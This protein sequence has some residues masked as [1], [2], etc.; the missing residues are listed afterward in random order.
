[1]ARIGKV[2]LAKSGWRPCPICHTTVEFGQP[3]D[4][5]GAEAKR[6]IESAF[7]GNT[8]DRV[9]VRYDEHGFG[10]TPAGKLPAFDAPMELA[11]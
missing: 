1:M 11:R 5:C 6:L 8:W 2:L 3:C 4:G 7:Y 10:I 9:A